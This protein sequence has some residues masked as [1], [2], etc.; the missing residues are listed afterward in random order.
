MGVEFPACS[1]FD[2]LA[3]AGGGTLRDCCKA[4]GIEFDGA[5]HCAIHDA[6]ADAHLFV[7]LLQ[8]HPGELARLSKLQPIA[9]PVLPQTAAVP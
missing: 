6:R 5:A 7:R 3:L 8:D 1:S 2:T 9:W 4:R